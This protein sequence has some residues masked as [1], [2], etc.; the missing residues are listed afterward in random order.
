[1]TIVEEAKINIRYTMDRHCEELVY[2][3]KDLMRCAGMGHQ[4]RGCMTC[5]QG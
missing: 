1:M 4:A 5:K 3:V 2:L